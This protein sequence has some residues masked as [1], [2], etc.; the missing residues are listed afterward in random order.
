[1]GRFQ[2]ETSCSFVIFS[3]RLAYIAVKLL[4]YIFKFS[5]LSGEDLTVLKRY[6]KNYVPSNNAKV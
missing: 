3:L 5:G 4:I 2:T 6:K 1:M